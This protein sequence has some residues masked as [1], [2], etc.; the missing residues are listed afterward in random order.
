MEI[1]NESVESFEKLYLQLQNSYP[2][3]VPTDT[4]Y[5]LC[6]LPN[7]KICIDRIFKYK[8]RSKDKPLS[9]FID[10]PEDWKLYGENKNVELVDK[11]VNIF[12]PG[13]LNIILKNKTNYNYMLNN[14]DSIAIGCVQN[15]TM[16]N[17]ISYIQSPIAITSA[18]ISGTADDILITENE[19]IKHMGNNVN[20]MLRSKNK[21]KYKSSSTIIKVTGNKIELLREG[22]IKFEEIKAK[23]GSG[24]QYE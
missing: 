4:N 14:S 15:K 10:E 21:S 2:I 8:K 3:I 6:S 9:L 1:L 12:W 19:A 7:N 5:N 17:I 11:L 16:R 13:P 22:D 23:L 18:N 24:I 20:Y